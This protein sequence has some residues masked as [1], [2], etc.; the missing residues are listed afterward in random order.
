M[1]KDEPIITYLSRFTQVRDELGDVGVTVLE[2][3]LVSFSLLGLHKSW[4]G[5]QDAVNCRENYPRWERLWNDCIQEEIQRGTRDGRSTKTKDEEN[6]SLAGKA[7]GKKGKGKAKSSQKG[8][9]K[10]KDL[11]KIKCFN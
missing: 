9:Q 8:E 6:F 2:H 1:S 5:F 11:S 7:K 4:Y 3:D 10:K